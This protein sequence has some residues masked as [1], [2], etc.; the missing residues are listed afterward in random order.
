VINTIRES[1]FANLYNPEN[2]FV[3]N[4]GGGAGNI[5]SY[6]YSQGEKVYEDIIDMVDREADGSDSL[7][8]RKSYVCVLD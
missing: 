2:M 8:V 7:E 3:A 4:D 1:P 5:W 6:G